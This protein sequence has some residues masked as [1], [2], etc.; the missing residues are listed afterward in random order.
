MYSVRVWMA[1][2][3]S[4]DRNRAKPID[5]LG[6]VDK[7]RA[8]K[9]L[10]CTLTAL[11]SE[12][13]T[14]NDSFIMQAPNPLVMLVNEMKARTPRK[15]QITLLGKTFWQFP[16]VFD[17][18]FT[19]QGCEFLASEVSQIVKEELSNMDNE[20]FFDF[21]EVGCGN[22]NT[23][24][25]VA[26]NHDNCRIWATDIN[27]NAIENTKENV[28]LHGL[29]NRVYAFTGDV[30][31][32]PDLKDRRFDLIFW[33]FPFIPF[34]SPNPQE[35]RVLSPLE[36]G[37][38]DPEYKGLREFLEGARDHLKKTGRILFAFSFKIG[39]EDLLK[40]VMA[41][42]GWGFRVLSEAEVEL[43]F[44]LYPMSMK[45]DVQLLEALCLE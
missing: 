23:L 35:K 39:S 12:S 13:S 11:R 27:P 1:M 17:S 10:V 18:E 22:G 28:Q 14:F 40:K 20:D 24:I 31:N 33:S 3:E 6:T 25:E 8:E 2:A 5:N 16:T 21:L 7:Y 44:T 37:L 26:L 32:V 15:R 43:K 29:E 36:R 34:A 4:S 45:N 38:V 9:K 41:E 30:Y 42:T 19:Q